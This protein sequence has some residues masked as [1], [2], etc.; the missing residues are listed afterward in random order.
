MA[1]APTTVRTVFVSI[2]LLVLYSYVSFSG[3]DIHGKA[4]VP[5]PGYVPPSS[6]YSPK[7]ENLQD[8]HLETSISEIRNLL[9]N[10]DK[11]DEEDI[12]DI[13]NMFNH[14]LNV[15]QGQ[16]ESTR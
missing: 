4:F 2:L 6:R 14:T 15:F 3:V 16:L 10:M 5:P 1:P 11:A 9:G 7:P 8:R 12:E 13:K